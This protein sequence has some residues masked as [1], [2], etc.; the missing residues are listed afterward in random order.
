MIINNKQW[1]WESSPQALPVTIDI[2]PVIGAVDNEYSLIMID[3]IMLD[4]ETA[5]GAE[6]F[7]SNTA[8]KRPWG[9]LDDRYPWAIIN[10]KDPQYFKTNIF[11]SPDFAD[12]VR[13]IMGG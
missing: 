5:L 3:E 1:L 11:K 10:V 7:H 13:E 4:P 12:A 9:R 8:L 6:I 2:N